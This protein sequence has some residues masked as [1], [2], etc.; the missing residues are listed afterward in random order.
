[1][2]KSFKF[3]NNNSQNTKTIEIVKL[4]SGATLLLA[5][6]GHGLIEAGVNNSNFDKNW[7]QIWPHITTMIY[8]TNVEEFELQLEKVPELSS[9]RA[10]LVIKSWITNPASLSVPSKKATNEFK[11]GIKAF[12]K[13]GEEFQSLLNYSESDSEEENLQI[14]T[15]YKERWED[16]KNLLPFEDEESESEIKTKP[17]AK[18][19]AKPAVK[20]T[21]Q[22]KKTADT[23]EYISHQYIKMTGKQLV[24]ILSGKKGKLLQKETAEWLCGTNC[25]ITI[26]SPIEFL[27]FEN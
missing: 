8:G 20:P 12:N 6:I 1:M 7:K 18:P 9:N 3:G 27:I 11:S 15:F 24:D 13:L 5:S 22:S 25:R 14:Q 10:K 23:L 16:F 17:E 21:P 26:V 2:S 4:N 19:E